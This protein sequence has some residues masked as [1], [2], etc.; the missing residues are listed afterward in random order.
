MREG[1]EHR[2]RQL[3]NRR[4]EPPATG[5]RLEAADERLNV[6]A[7][8]RRDRSDG[9]RPAA[10]QPELAGYRTKSGPHG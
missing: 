4:E 9:D 3:A 6:V 5:F 2:F 8:R 10:G 7:I 1:I